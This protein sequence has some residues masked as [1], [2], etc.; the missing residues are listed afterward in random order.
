ME[1]IEFFLQREIR[2]FREIREILNTQ[3]HIALLLNIVIIWLIC[4]NGNLFS[5]YSE[6]CYSENA[7]NQRNYCPT[8]ISDFDFDLYIWIFKSLFGITRN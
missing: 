2:D 4:N 3:N 1:Y 8:A 7:F 6:S 5:C